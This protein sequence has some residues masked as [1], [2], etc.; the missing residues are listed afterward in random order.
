[1]P[2]SRAW[3]TDSSVRWPLYVLPVAV[4]V[5]VAFA[6]VT[7]G[8]TLPYRAARVWGGPTDGERMSLRLE[9]FEVTEDLGGGRAENVVGRGKVAVQLRAGRLEAARQVELDVEGGAEVAFDLAGAVRP[10]E[11]SVESE[12]NVLAAGTLALDAARWAA[13]AR[14]RGGWSEL[15]VGPYLLRVA[16]ARGV[17]AVPFEE[18]L[19]LDV[20]LG[21]LPVA[22]ALVTLE[23]SGARVSE[24][25]RRT[26]TRGRVVFRVAPDEHLPTARVRILEGAVEHQTAFGLAVVPGALRVT[27]S[28]GELLIEAPVPRDLA[29][30][31]LVTPN[32]RLLGGRLLLKPDARGGSSAQLPLPALGVTPTHAVVASERDLRSTAAVGWPLEL[33]P[34]GEPARSFD[35]V[36][37]L[38]LDGGPRAVL[39]ERARRHRV[40][41]IVAAFVAA[42]SLVEIALLLA[43]TR[44]GDRALDAHLERSGLAA[45]DAERLAPRRSPAILLA[46]LAVAVGFLV[47]TLVAILRMR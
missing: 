38:L 11:L 12:G 27:R 7:A 31:A 2:L 32:E 17:L 6:L 23:V 25:Q 24:K 30:F 36:E 1:L 13:A 41:W 8:S 47:V 10:L 18:E 9:V 3:D 19:W 4:V 14:R 43:L 29:Y 26:D 42:A 34:G 5:I 21:A 37:A 15:R 33:V 16:P 44:R 45:A 35:A 28:G 46:L 39:R 22:N 20:S 40:R